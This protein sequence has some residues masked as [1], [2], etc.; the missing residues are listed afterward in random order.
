MLALL[1]ELGTDVHAGEGPGEP[2]GLLYR[3][4]GEKAVNCVRWLLEQGVQVNHEVEGQV[5]CLAL[6]SAARTGNLDLVKMFVPEERSWLRGRFGTVANG[7]PPQPFASNTRLSCLLVLEGS[8]N[9][10]FVD[11]PNGRRVCFYELHPL[12]AEERDLQQ[13]QG[14]KALLQAFRDHGVQ[15]TVNIARPSVVA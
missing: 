14:I 3:A 13:A 4:A 1:A 2:E 8:S 7:E 11:L 5:R 15:R 9:F 12:H 6:S 10:C